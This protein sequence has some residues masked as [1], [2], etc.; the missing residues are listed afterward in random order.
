MVS[1]ILTKIIGVVGHFMNVHEVKDFVLYGLSN[2]TF[3][4]VKNS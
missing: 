3:G 4:V 2:T 1:P